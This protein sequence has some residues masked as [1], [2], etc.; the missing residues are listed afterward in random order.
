MPGQPGIFFES[1]QEEVVPIKISN[2]YL[3]A[4]FMIRIFIPGRDE[5]R[6]AFNIIFFRHYDAC[7]L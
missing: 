3:T 6:F 4:T 1:K 7:I 5:K 2:S